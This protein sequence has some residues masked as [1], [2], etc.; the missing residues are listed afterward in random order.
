MDDN[1]TK[2]YKY[3]KL[4][5]L[6]RDYIV[7]T[8]KTTLMIMLQVAYGGQNFSEWKTNKKFDKRNSILD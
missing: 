6:I 1:F 7:I 8:Y 5:P 4:I 2:F 3:R